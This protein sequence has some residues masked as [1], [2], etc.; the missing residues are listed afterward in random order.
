MANDFIQRRI[1]S[2]A[3]TLG[4][5]AYAI[6]KAIAKGP[7][8]ETVKRYLA[9]RSALNSRYVSAICRVLELDLV[10]IERR[11]SK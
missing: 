7:T 8:E 9:G 1:A 6:A 10:P 5:T 11:R 4:M 3:E 2:R